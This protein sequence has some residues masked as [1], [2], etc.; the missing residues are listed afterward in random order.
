MTYLCHF[1]MGKPKV[2]RILKDQ[3]W[4]AMDLLL[5]VGMEKPR[6]EEFILICIYSFTT[7]NINLFRNTHINE[8]KNRELTTP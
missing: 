8:E 6:R 5:K 2:F 3:G 4:F 7:L 1:T